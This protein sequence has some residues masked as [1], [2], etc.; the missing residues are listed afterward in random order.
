MPLARFPVVLLGPGN[1][2]RAV[3]NRI[4][5]SQ[6]LFQSQLKIGFDVKAVCDSSGCIVA[7]ESSH[8]LDVNDVLAWKESNPLAAHKHGHKD[9]SA[10]QALVSTKSFLI[11]CSASAA[12]T[13]LLRWWIER[14]GNVVL[15]NKKPLSES[16][17]DFLAF[18]SPEN[19]NRFGYESTAGAGTPFIAAVKGIGHAGDVVRSMH[20]TFSGTLGYITS[21]LD[22]NKKFSDLVNKAFSEGLTEPDPR[23]DLNGMDVARKA[24]ILARTIGWTRNLSDLH[25]E[26]LFPPALSGLPLKEFFA[27]LPSLD[28]KFTARIEA[29]RANDSVLRYVVSIR[30]GQVEVGL[31]EVP[32][33]SPLGRLR[34]TDNILEVFSDV[35]YKQPLVIQGAGAGAEVTASGV[36]CDMVNIA[37][38][39]V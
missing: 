7:P 14:G 3:L 25:V 20:G 11:D 15:A 32:A 5:S 2:G 4:V 27:A 1:V 34:G 38:K 24:L 21:G 18:T 16:M 35:Y 23:D 9:I 36:V 10:V 26:P 37:L 8:A 30:D 29:A 19:H 6:T 13:G 31:K 22:E 33:E 12:T 28:E 39:H 17:D